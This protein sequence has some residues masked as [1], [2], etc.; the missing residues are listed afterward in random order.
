MTALKL[1]TSIL[2]EH[3]GD[4]VRIVGEDLFSSRAKTLSEII[5]TTK[6]TRKQVRKN[7]EI[8]V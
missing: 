6:L 2:Q 8:I 5:K 7:D 4:S 1:C 3:F